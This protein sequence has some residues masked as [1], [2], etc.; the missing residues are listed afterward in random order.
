[1]SNGHCYCTFGHM[2]EV[3]CATTQGFGVICLRRVWCGWFAEVYCATTQSFGVICLRRGAARLEGR[4]V[5]LCAMG[6]H[7]VCFWGGM[8]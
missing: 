1:M 4:S 6:S 3:C 7:I 2:G 8:G 5:V